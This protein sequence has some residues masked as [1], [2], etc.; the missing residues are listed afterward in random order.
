MPLQNWSSAEYDTDYCFKTLQC[1]NSPSDFE[2][3]L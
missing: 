1:R 3:G 2:S